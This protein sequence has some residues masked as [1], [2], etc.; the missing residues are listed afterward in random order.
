MTKLEIAVFIIVLFGFL[1]IFERRTSNLINKKLSD[2]Q[3]NIPEVKP[4]SPVVIYKT[5]DSN[6]TSN[7]KQIPAASSTN[8]TLPESQKKSKKPI[9]KSR[10][11]YIY[12]KEVEE[13]IPDRLV[14]SYPGYVGTIIGCEKEKPYKIFPDQIACNQPNYKTAENYYRYYFKYPIIP[15]PDLDY[16]SPAGYFTNS[17]YGKIDDHPSQN[18]NFKIIPT[19][20]KTSGKTPFPSNYQFV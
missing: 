10:T 13:N 14:S 18:H 8:P 19:E 15:N 16:F 5:V 2:I 20:Y 1:F 4:P 9:L 7:S 11:P 3:I 17:S 6:S 12:E